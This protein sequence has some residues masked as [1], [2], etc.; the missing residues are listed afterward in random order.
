MFIIVN[1][2]NDFGKDASYQ[3]KA[4]YQIKDTIENN[5]DT[6]VSI[7]KMPSSQALKHLNKIHTQF[8]NFQQALGRKSNL[9]PCRKF[10]EL[11]TTFEHSINITFN[12]A[13]AFAPTL[14]KPINKHHRID[15]KLL[16]QID[17][18]LQYVFS[19]KTSKV[20]LDRVFVAFAN[21]YEVITYFDK[22]SNW[23]NII[24][25]AAASLQLL[26]FW[27]DFLLTLDN[28]NFFINLCIEK[29]NG[30]IG[31]ISNVFE[32]ENEFN[33]LIDERKLATKQFCPKDLILYYIMNFYIKKNPISSPSLTWTN[34]DQFNSQLKVELESSHLNGHVFNFFFNLAQ[35]SGLLEKSLQ[36]QL[37]FILWNQVFNAFMSTFPL[38]NNNDTDL[39]IEELLSQI[40]KLQPVFKSI[41]LN[42]L[43]DEKCRKN[44]AWYPLV[45]NL[46]HAFESLVI[47]DL[48]IAL[49]YN[50]KK[51]EKQA[52]LFLTKAQ[53]NYSFIIQHSKK[54][55]IVS[56][57]SKE[58]AQ[59][60]LGSLDSRL[61]RY[62]SHEGMDEYL[63]PF[64]LRKAE[65][66]IYRKNMLA[67]LEK[68]EQK[69]KQKKTIKEKVTQRLAD[70]RAKLQK[71]KYI[72]IKKLNHL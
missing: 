27:R 32:R 25:I 23:G 35:S 70:E 61:K 21:T 72:K 40:Q 14:V 13:N 11:L 54:I 15:S 26:Q 24:V 56:K 4:Y 68:T 46:W 7:S 51:N 31:E 2:Y 52:A 66:D 17:R 65:K 10:Y 53:N 71:S 41:V 1:M 47:I 42:I 45:D 43:N 16:K 57:I 9:I 60:D 69:N 64:S 3:T 6:L 49:Y 34:L 36:H 19:L 29:L 63:Q 58:R 5:F 33:N 44:P 18:Q 59:K 48:Q 62:P 8:K 38:Q 30:F 37:I 22:C 39:K 67:S 12:E 55:I 28:D 50:F 20:N